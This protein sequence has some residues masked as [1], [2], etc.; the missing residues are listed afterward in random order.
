[1]LNQRGEPQ[2]C[3]QE[4]KESR[5]AIGLPS[6]ISCTGSNAVER[7]LR[8]EPCPRGNDRGWLAQRASIQGARG[9]RNSRV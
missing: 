2:E 1:M 4:F 8:D 5:R 3:C 7:S 9:L 6:A